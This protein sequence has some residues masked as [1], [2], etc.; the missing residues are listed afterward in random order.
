M[1]AP[2]TPEGWKGMEGQSSKSSQGWTGCAAA[3]AR[4]REGR[5]GG[6]G[7]RE[8]GLKAQCSFLFRGGAAATGDAMALSLEAGEAKKREIRPLFRECQYVWW[9]RRIGYL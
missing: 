8:R 2:P 9:K 3:R 4:R 7:W 5:G 6:G 1:A